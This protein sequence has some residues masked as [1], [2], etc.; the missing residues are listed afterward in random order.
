MSAVESSLATDVVIVLEL[1]SL[2]RLGDF[3]LANDV[4]AGTLKK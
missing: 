2:I 4:I 1:A 3:L